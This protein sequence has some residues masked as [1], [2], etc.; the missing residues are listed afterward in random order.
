M[1]ANAATRAVWKAIERRYALK[2]LVVDEVLIDRAR[3]SISHDG[4]R[5]ADAGGVIIVGEHIAKMWEAT[6]Q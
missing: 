4:T 6:Q 1:T 3:P 5:S 2:K